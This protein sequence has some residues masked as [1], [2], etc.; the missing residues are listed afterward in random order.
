MSIVFVDPK[1]TVI[2]NEIIVEVKD[3]SALKKTVLQFNDKLRTK[4]SEA[5]VEGSVPVDFGEL[6]VSII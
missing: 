2:A 1:C 6:P 4:F 5:A 3:K